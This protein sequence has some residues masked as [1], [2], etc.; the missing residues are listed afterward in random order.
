MS[1]PLSSIGVSSAMNT[2]GL[3]AVHSTA[4]ADVAPSYA[5][6][7]SLTAVTLIVIF[8]LSNPTTS[9]VLLPE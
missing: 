7:A 1:V 5:T 6:G 3:A 2:Q 9:Q 8:A 4:S